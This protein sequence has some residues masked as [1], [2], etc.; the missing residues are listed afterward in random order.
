MQKIENV[1]TLGNLLLVVHRKIHWHPLFK[2]GYQP[3]VASRGRELFVQ[4]RPGIS[5]LSLCVGIGVFDGF[6]APAGNCYEPFMI[7]DSDGAAAVAD[8]PESPQPPHCPT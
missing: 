5:V 7:E 2:F 6:V 8:E 3:C 1:T 4:G